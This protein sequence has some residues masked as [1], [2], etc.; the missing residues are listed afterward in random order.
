M[1][2]IK[3]ACRRSS[4]AS[5]VYFFHARQWRAVLHDLPGFVAKQSLGIQICHLLASVSLPVQDRRIEWSLRIQLSK[6]LREKS[7][8]MVVD[9]SYK[10]V[11]SS[12]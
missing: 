11:E 5:V 4:N 1:T 9:F 12:Q 3:Q 8:Q 6:H 7:L 10:A 2:T